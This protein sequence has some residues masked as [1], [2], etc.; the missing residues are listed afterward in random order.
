MA[1]W[2]VEALC[3]CLVNFSSYLFVYYWQGRNQE[4]SLKDPIFINLFFFLSISTSIMTTISTDLV[5]VVTE[6]DNVEIDDDLHLQA[7]LCGSI[8]ISHQ[9]NMIVMTTYILA[10]CGVSPSLYLLG[11]KHNLA[12]ISPTSWNIK[13]INY[14]VTLSKLLFQLFYT[15]LSKY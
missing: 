11:M 4:S 7:L 9:M 14:Q 5:I 10:T 6:T 13:T 2:T 12:Q 8:N 3:T 15:N 1:I